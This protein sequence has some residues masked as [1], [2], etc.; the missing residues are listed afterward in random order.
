MHGRL[1]IPF[2]FRRIIFDYALELGQIDVCSHGEDDDNHPVSDIMRIVTSHLTSPLLIGRTI[3]TE[4]AA[5]NIPK[6]VDMK[7]CT[8]ASVLKFLGDLSPSSRMRVRSIRFTALVTFP[9]AELMEL[10]SHPTVK[11]NIEE[12]LGR[13]IYTL[14]A[15]GT[16]D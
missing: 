6:T 11:S 12:L 14:I 3:T 16:E 4:L 7:I 2:E 9:G 8:Y 10:G 5:R 1:D 15:R 13:E